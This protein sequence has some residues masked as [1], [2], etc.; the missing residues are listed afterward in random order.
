MAHHPSVR[1]VLLFAATAL[2]ATVWTT[3]VDRDQ[4]GAPFKKPPVRDVPAVAPTDGKP[5]RIPWTTSRVVGSPEPPPPYKTV[6]AFEKLTFKNPTVLAMTP[7]SKRLFVCE[8]RGRIYS[9]PENDPVVAKA[10]LVIDLKQQL[11]SIPPASNIRNMGELY[12]LAFHPQFERNRF[13]YVCY[14]VNSKTPNEQLPDGTRLSRFVVSE[15]DPPTFDPDSEQILLTWLGGGH[16]G[17]CL[18]FGP[19]GY[20]YVT[21][22]DGSFPNPPDARLAGQDLTDLL[23]EVLRIDVDHEQDGR[24]Y[25]IPADNPFVGR[26]D[27]RPEVWA[28]GFRNP[29]KITFDRA[30]GD[31]WLGDV[32][33]ES[34][35]LVHRVVKGGNY[36]WSIVEGLQPVRPDAKRGPTPIL[37]PAIAL[38]HSEAASITGGYVY[39]GRQFPELA[40]KY[41]FGDWETHRLWAATWDGSQVTSRLELVDP[42]LR[43]VA[44]GQNHDGELYIADYDAGTLHQLAKNDTPS[45]AHER[46]PRRLSETGLFV[47]RPLAPREA[48]PSA[49]ATSDSHDARLTFRSSKESDEN[50]SGLSAPGSSSRGASRLRWEPTAGVI[51]FEINVPMWA[52]G[53]TAERWLALPDATSIQ[54][55]K[56]Q[57]P[58]PGTIFNR[59]FIFPK[60]AVLAKTISMEAERGNSESKRFIETQLLHYDGLRW[61]AYSYRWN[62]EQTD[63]DLVPAL[64]DQTSISIADAAAPG[65]RRELTWTFHGRA[66][67]A[68][69]H[70]SWAMHT[71]AFNIPQLNRSAAPPPLPSGEGL[72]HTNQ[73]DDFVRR[74]VIVPAKEE[75]NAATLPR[76]TNPHDESQPLDARA[77]SYLQANCAHCHQMGGTGTADFDVRFDKSLEQTKLVNKKPLQG[78]FQIDQAQL[79]VPGDPFRSV[80]FYRVANEGKGHMPIIGSETVDDA[81]ASLISRWIASLPQRFDDLALIDKLRELDEATQLARER[82]SAVQRLDALARQL[83]E[84]AERPNVTD[85]DREQAQKLD[86]QQSV[87]RAASRAKQRHET[88]DQLLNSPSRALLLSRTLAEQPLADGLQSEVLQAA[89]NHNDA[90]VRDLFERFRPADQRPKRLGAIIR[91]EKLLALAGDTQRGRELFFRTT[92][93]SCKQCHKVGSEGGS[94]GPELTHVGKKLDKVKL[95]ESILEPSKTIDPKFVAYLV[96][97]DD[98]KTTTGLLVEQT[99]EHVIL[100]TPQGQ[101]AKFATS[102]V[103]VLLP[104]RQSLMPELLLKDMT[105]EQVADLLT[106]LESLK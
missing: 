98:G 38:P 30:T 3:S 27:A 94:V 37:P 49:P 15:S 56:Q 45:D 19:D 7:S 2:V 101:D 79:V 85:A 54:W 41:I 104:Q 78:A 28:Y 46:F 14:T 17:G 1:F 76:L 81:G 35:E 84:Q 65:G 99:A 93:V 10:D 20:L 87:E 21:T 60:D 52:D 105:A 47:R 29:W 51:P 18:E 53:A 72:S 61:H 103:E 31:L 68:R 42:T 13:A 57:Q 34:F 50:S 71:L 102:N 63:A 83:V 74:G 89:W 26:K 88:I 16:N 58:I 23:S 97:T 55:H 82:E 43:I 25:R 96:Q 62:D 91:P 67:C 64:G 9:F 36:G 11:R 77:R 95:L 70:N 48:L 66:A 40:G 32:G 44:F 4:N 86:A 100:R 90:Q 75:L 24:P 106:F 92:G 73:L 33:W 22:G 5:V 12:G 69:C 39:R 6:R 8:Q 59:H 80:L